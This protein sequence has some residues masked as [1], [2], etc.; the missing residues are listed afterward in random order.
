MPFSTKINPK[1]INATKFN[2]ILLSDLTLQIYN[3]RLTNAIKHKMSAILKAF[4]MKTLV[5]IL[6][7]TVIAGKTSIRTKDVM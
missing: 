3:I 4:M 1:A 5:N 6:I 2:Y 7:G